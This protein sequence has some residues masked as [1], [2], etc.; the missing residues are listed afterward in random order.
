MKLHRSLYARP[1]IRSEESSAPRH[2]L[3][4]GVSP[5]RCLVAAVARPALAVSLAAQL[6]W[7]LIDQAASERPSLGRCSSG[8]ASCS[9]R[10]CQGLPCC[11]SPVGVYHWVSTHSVPMS[12]IR[13]SSR[14]VS[15]R[16]VS[17]RPVFGHL[18][19]SSGI[20]PSGRLVSARRRPASWSP[21]VR[22]VTSISCAEAQGW[23]WGSRR[24]GG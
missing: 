23:P 17:S 24:C 15:S 13:L 8:R 12:G 18:V 21:A 19:G 6:S 3:D 2:R 5:C 4:G 9:R 1:E 7:L 22:P 11:P 16:P 20:R 14:P 10:E